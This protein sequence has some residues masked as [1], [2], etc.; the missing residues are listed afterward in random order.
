MTTNLEY[1]KVFYHVA[2]CGS[3][4]EAAQK[5]NVSQP[6]VS[7][8]I[9]Q[10]EAS[11][12]VK[13]FKRVSKG[14]GLTKEAEALYE[15]V[16]R[17]Y[18]EIEAGEEKIR[19]LISLD[20]GEVRVGASD[21]TLKYFLLPYLERF[22]ELYPKIKIVVT[23]APTPETLENLKNHTVDFGIVST[24]FTL[25]DSIVARP[26]REI[27]DIFA[28]GRKFLKYKNK[29]LDFKDLEKL[30]I[31]ALENNTSSRVYIDSFL[32]EQSVVL[33]PE[34]ELA[35]SDMIVEFALKNLGIGCVMKDF[36]KPYLDEGKLFELRFD[37]ILP[38]RQL[39]LVTGAKTTLSHAAEA[40]LDIVCANDSD[41]R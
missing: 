31:I 23:N 24:P 2:T 37:K 10:L 3:L 33:K 39:M 25:T 32:K 28:A 8:A 29:S 18:A 34:F 15:H 13:L 36:A 27:E 5:L 11:L 14:V 16:K 20:E 40:L 9:R 38:K 21:M 41:W 30:P 4:T 26:V 1:Y 12:K 22:H 7:Q 35:T 19:Q 17:A 6:A